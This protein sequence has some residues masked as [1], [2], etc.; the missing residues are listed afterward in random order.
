MFVSIMVTKIYIFKNTV[1]VPE[2]RVWVPNVAV[3][4]FSYFQKFL[5]PP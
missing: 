2:Y 3:P 1:Q 4:C 5:D